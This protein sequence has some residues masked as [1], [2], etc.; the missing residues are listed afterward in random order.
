MRE[1][2]RKPI[3][4]RELRPFIFEAPRSI[5]DYHLVGARVRCRLVTE[6]AIARR[7]SALLTLA[8]RASRRRPQGE[9]R[10]CA[11][12]RAARRIRLLGLSRLTD[13]GIARVGWFFGRWSPDRRCHR[14]LF[15]GG[16]SGCQM[17]VRKSNS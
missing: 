11:R 14:N 2:I 13:L 3:G 10:R 6:L 4:V 16:F 9:S 12:V 1:L 5:R 8:D 15:W 17:S 7:L